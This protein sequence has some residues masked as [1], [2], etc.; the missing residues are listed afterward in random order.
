MPNKDARIQEILRMLLE[1]S[2]GNFFFRLERSKKDDNLEAMIVI[3]NMLAEEIQESLIH[4][5]H[6]NPR[7]LT[8]HIVQMCFLIDEKGIIRM[9][10]QKACIILSDLYTNV[11]NQPFELLLNNDSKNKWL[12]KWKVLNKKDFYDTSLELTFKT[13]ENLL[14]PNNCYITTFKEKNS[15]RQTLLTIVHQTKAAYEL[16]KELK[17]SVLH[18]KDQKETLLKHNPKITKQ[19]PA[20]TSED[21]HKIRE[22]QEIILNNLEKD[23]PNLKDFALQLGTNEFKLKHGFKELYGVSV[24][25]Y[26]IRERLRKAKILV[27]FSRIPFKSIAFMVGFKTNSYFSNAFTKKYGYTPS[28][29]RKET[30]NT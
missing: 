10:N 23:L 29:L 6:I 21:L 27:Q 3:L 1:M 12:E 19:K 24:H 17:K 4:Q 15:K 18:L 14:M 22:G 25:Q 5:G 2:S 9:V 16:E 30:L 13:K 28:E 26:I 7:G 8:K 11:I 20:L